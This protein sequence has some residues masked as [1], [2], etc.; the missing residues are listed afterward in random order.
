MHRVLD[1]LMVSSLSEAS[2]PFFLSLHQVQAILHIGDGGLFPDDIKLYHRPVLRSGTLPA[3]QLR[4][5]I[6]FLRESLR[7]GRRV[8]VVGRTGA[9]VAAAYLMEM[10]FSPAQAIAMVRADQCPEPDH[11]YVEEHASE[12]ERRSAVQIRHLD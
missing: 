7:A 6:E 8:L 9:T 12:L 4:D 11:D 2:D 1:R 3:D 10:G 5:G